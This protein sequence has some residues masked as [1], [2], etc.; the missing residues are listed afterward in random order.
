[1]LKVSAGTASGPSGQVIG[2]Q[3]GEYVDVRAIRGINLLSVAEP[4]EIEHQER[5][6]AILEH[7]GVIAAAP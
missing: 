2:L 4:I 1:M 7:E 3:I 6:E 5:A